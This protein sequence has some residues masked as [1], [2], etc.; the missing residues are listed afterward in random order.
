[1]RRASSGWNSFAANWL[2]PRL[3]AFRVEHPDLNIVID[4]NPQ[5]CDPTPG[6]VDL[7]IRYGDGAWPGLEAE[8]L[9]IAPLVG[10]ASPELVGPTPPQD[11]AELAQYPWFQEPGTSEASTWMETHGVTAKAGIMAVPNNLAI[12]AARAGQG[13]TI[14]AKVAVQADLD[15]GRLVCLFEERPTAAYYL[16]TRPGVKRPPLRK[17]LSWLKREVKTS[18]N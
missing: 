5:R 9:V 1:M 10:V 13:V 16:V 12:D 17:L 14:T 15:A 8:F 6:G 7:A 18:G 4:P 11:L 3:A 2:M